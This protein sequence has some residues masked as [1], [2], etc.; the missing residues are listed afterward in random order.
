MKF[1]LIFEF[2]IFCITFLLVTV[3]FF[4]RGIYPIRN[5][6]L[7]IILSHSSILGTRLLGSI[8]YVLSFLFLWTTKDTLPFLILPV[9]ISI[10]I[11]II[12]IVVSRK[13]N[14]TFNILYS[15]DKAAYKEILYNTLNKYNVLFTINKD[16]VILRKSSAR[17]EFYEHGFYI[18][19]YRSLPN[20]KALLEELETNIKSLPC[21][22]QWKQDFIHRSFIMILIAILII[23]IWIGLFILTPD[24]FK[25]F[26][27]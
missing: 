21:K 12:C 26:M 4:I 27:L 9:A 17:I 22:E 15:E 19:K 11:A 5:K 3:F 1:E 23:G 14:I 24:K 8:I 20:F 18:R 2:L 13:I 25:Y 16:K 10:P 7:G 6:R